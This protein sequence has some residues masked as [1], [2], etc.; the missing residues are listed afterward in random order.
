[1]TTKRKFW[2]RHHVGQAEPLAG[3]HPGQD[4]SSTQEPTAFVSI[5]GLQSEMVC[6]VQTVYFLI[7]QAEHDTL[8]HPF[9]MLGVEIRSWRLCTC[10]Q[11]PFAIYHPSPYQLIESDNPFE[12]SIGSCRSPICQT[13]AKNARHRLLSIKHTVIPVASLHYQPTAHTGNSMLAPTDLYTAKYSHSSTFS[14]VN[15]SLSCTNAVHCKP[16]CNHF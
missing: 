5:F 11:Q 2:W 9:H 7:F 1:V 16:T 10:T 12:A 15:A 14:A 8:L 6:R 4:S 3:A 13:S